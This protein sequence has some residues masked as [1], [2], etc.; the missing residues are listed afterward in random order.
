M[1]F[2]ILFKPMTET[3]SSLRTESNNLICEI[4]SDDV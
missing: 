1:S 2:I 4:Y 3:F